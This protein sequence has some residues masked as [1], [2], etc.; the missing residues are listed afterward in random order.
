ML[1]KYWTPADHD[2]EYDRRRRAEIRGYF[3]QNFV[4]N[5]EKCG[6]DNTYNIVSQL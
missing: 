1:K 3:D 5:I 2:R 4:P 6:L